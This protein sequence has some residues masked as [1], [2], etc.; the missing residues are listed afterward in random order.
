MT[1]DGVRALARECGFK[2]RDA[3]GGGAQ[4]QRAG[5]MRSVGLEI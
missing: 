2:L 3:A 5:L 4:E 1:A